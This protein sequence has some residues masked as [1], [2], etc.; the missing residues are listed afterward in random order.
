MSRSAHH[1]PPKRRN[2]GVGRILDQFTCTCGARYLGHTTRL[3]PKR[4]AEHCPASLR[5]G[6]TRTVHSSIPEHLVDSGRNIQTKEVFKIMYVS[7]KSCTKGFKK[8]LLA[9]TEAIASKQLKLELCTKRAF[10]RSLTLPWP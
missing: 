7:V 2:S 8:R 4:I 9:T 1:Q 5:G 6:P 10:M 3:L